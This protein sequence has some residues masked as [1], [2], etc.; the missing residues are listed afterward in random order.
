MH[1]VFP[2]AVTERDV[3]LDS[4]LWWAYIDLT[5]ANVYAVPRLVAN[6]DVPSN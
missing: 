3:F 2:N 5:E 1:L 6:P 4:H